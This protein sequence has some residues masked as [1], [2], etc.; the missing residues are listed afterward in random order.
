MEICTKITLQ[1]AN[2]ITYVVFHKSSNIKNK[3]DEQKL[4]GI[5][6]LVR[7]WILKLCTEQDLREIRNASETACR[8]ENTLTPLSVIVEKHRGCIQSI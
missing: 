6:I 8:I 1:E 5:T 2:Q 3:A 4:E 7:N